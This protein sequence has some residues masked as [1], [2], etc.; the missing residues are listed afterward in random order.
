MAPWSVYIV[1]VLLLSCSLYISRAETSSAQCPSSCD[2]VD[3]WCSNTFGVGGSISSRNCGDSSFECICNGVSGV[4][5]TRDVDSC[6]WETSFDQNAPNGSFCFSYTGLCPTDCD[7]INPWT[8]H[9]VE[10]ITCVSENDKFVFNCTTCAGRTYSIEG[11][12]K[13]CKK[14]YSSEI[15][16][17]P[18]TTCNGNGCCRKPGT[19][20][21]QCAC[22]RDP[23]RGFWA[24]PCCSNCD[25]AYE[26]G[27]DH[28]TKPR[29]VIQTI[30]SSIGSTWTMV[31]P[32]LAVLFLFV[33]LGVIRGECESDRGF[34]STALRKTGLSAVQVARRHQRGLFHSKYI[35]K[36]PAKSRCFLNEEEGQTHFRGPSA[37]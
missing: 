29:P 17:D 37:Y 12:S 32:N 6:T 18:A 19:S 30:L 3:E 11:D 15:A 31:L 2:T 21:D 14:E 9:C 20:L 24:Q 5:V 16:C 26:P 10:D 34:Q 13:S 23:I 33:V 35:P 36:R 25:P 8:Q 7:S 1:V 27:K 22:F 28:C 4:V